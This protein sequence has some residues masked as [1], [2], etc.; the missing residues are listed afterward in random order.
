M[1][2]AVAFALAM[3]ALVPAFVFVALLMFTADRLMA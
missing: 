3:L 2:T 1:T